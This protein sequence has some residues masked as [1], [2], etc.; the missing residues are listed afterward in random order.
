[1][2]ENSELEQFNILVDYEGAELFEARGELRGGLLP[3]RSAPR[4]AI[5]PHALA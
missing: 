3:E 5:L 2:I 4:A 1:M